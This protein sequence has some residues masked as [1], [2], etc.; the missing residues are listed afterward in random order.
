MINRL[1]YSFMV[2]LQVSCGGDAPTADATFASPATAT[3]HDFYK[4]CSVCHESTRPGPPHDE[5]QDCVACHQ[6]ND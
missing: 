6:Y 3:R 5:F 1:F 2:L 4:E